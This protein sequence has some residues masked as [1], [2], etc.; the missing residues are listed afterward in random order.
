MTSH[1]HKNYQYYFFLIRDIAED[2]LLRV[3]LIGLTIFP[4]ILSSSVELRSEIFCQHT[5]YYWPNAPDFL[6]NQTTVMHNIDTVI[7]INVFLVH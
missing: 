4:H 2:A 1:M 3:I 5:Q 6:P 7:S